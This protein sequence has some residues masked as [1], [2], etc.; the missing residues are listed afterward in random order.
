MN[1]ILKRILVGVCIAMVMMLV[2][3][4]SHAAVTWSTALTNYNYPAPDV[5][6][7]AAFATQEANSPGTWSYTG[8]NFVSVTKYACNL[9]RNSSG[10]KTLFVYANASGTCDA[11]TTVD[12]TTGLCSACPSPSFMFN[13]SCHAPC[14]S[15]QVHRPGGTQDCEVPGRDGCP[16]AMHNDST[17]GYNQ[18]VKDCT[19]GQ[20]E[21]KTGQCVP[22]KFCAPYEALDANGFCRSNTSPTAPPKPP[23]NPPNDDGTCPSGATNIGTDSAGTPICRGT[24]TPPSDKPSTR[25]PTTTTTNP[26]GSTTTTDSGST[27]N[28]DGSKT[29]DST[30]CTTA[31][32]G[33]K[34]CNTSIST[35]TKPDG[36]QGKSDGKG[37]GGGGAPGGLCDKNP[38]LNLCKNSQVTGGCA[39]GV[40]T[41]ACTG[42]A[43]Q[44]AILR[45]QKKEYCENTKPNPMTDLGTQIRAGND[46][47][48]GDIDKA[49]AGT[50]VDLSDQQIDSSGFLGGGSCFANRSLSFAGR[51]VP[52]DFSVL[53]GGITPLRYAVL[54]CASIAAFLLVSK[55]II[56][57]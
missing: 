15:G 8:S 52:I 36:T 17:G 18:C 49:I 48:Q 25:N 22:K 3:K 20:D 12:P 5:A 38:E 26:D 23:L 19:S 43:I 7:Q 2:H 34:T 41:T 29:T 24:G 21:N 37:S 46:P 16:A 51:A 10:E 4:V 1:N 55:S 14:P 32:D 28:S 40:D 56:Q 44:C 57:G 47:K 42:D 33:T 31:S 45:Q 30:T 53:C 9:V 39:A 13:G 11:G 6:C 54:F 35:G 50:D 27:T